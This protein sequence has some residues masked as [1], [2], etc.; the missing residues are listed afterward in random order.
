MA[1][2]S[3]GLGSTGSRAPTPRQLSGGLSQRPST[4]IRR[5][6]RRC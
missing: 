4:M 1:T 6:T 5:S 3:S 2:A